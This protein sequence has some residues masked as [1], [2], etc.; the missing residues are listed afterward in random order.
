MRVAI[1]GAGVMGKDV[2]ITC[3]AHGHDVILVDNDPQV[4]DSLG[5]A[6]R[7][8]VRQFKLTTPGASEWDSGA[9]K[10]AIEV[11][12]D[13]SAVAGADWIVENISERIEAKQDLYGRLADVVGMAHVAINTSCISITQLAQQ[14]PAPD[15][16]LGM[17]FMNPV[18]LIDGIEVIR[19]HRTSEETVQ[20]SRRFAESLGKEA[21]V[22]DDAPGFVSNR[23]SHLFMNEAA[24]L[25]QD[26]VAGPAEIDAVFTKG[27]GHSMGPLATADLI[28]LDTVVD[29]L[30]V[31]YREFQDSKF[32]C[33]PLL[34]RMVR[35]GDL[36]RKSGRGF[37]TY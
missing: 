12:A 16:V 15:R 29:S 18:P 13:L 3:A 23:L 11:G 6:I 1:V 31:L 25:V 20:E 17:H 34:R 19:G 10:N 14:L 28:G 8:L 32:R 24:F 27:Y 30:D 7:Q 2:A 9:I 36:G 35:A 37:F 4:R 5:A 26:G 22:V 21:I 33:C